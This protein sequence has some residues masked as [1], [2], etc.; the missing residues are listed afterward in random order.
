MASG[1]GL[2]NIDD[3][4]GIVDQ[5]LVASSVEPEPYSGIFDATKLA[6]FIAIANDIN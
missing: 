4:A 2:G 3:Y 6:E 1:I 5:V